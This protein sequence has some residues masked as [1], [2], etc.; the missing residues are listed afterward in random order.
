MSSKQDAHANTCLHIVLNKLRLARN[1]LIALTILIKRRV[2]PRAPPDVLRAIYQLVQV[3]YLN[4]SFAI[5]TVDL[6]A[7][8]RLLS[9]H[10]K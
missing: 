4:A 9:I 3:D 1:A 6:S 7:C 5:E 10:A 2:I 8:L